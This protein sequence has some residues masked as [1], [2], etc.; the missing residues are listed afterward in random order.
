MHGV[1]GRYRRIWSVTSSIGTHRLAV[2]PSKTLRPPLVVHC[3]TARS[4]ASKAASGQRLSTV[5]LSIAGTCILLAAPAAMTMIW[6]SAPPLL[7]SDAEASTRPH[8]EN[9]YQQTTVE[10]VV[11]DKSTCCDI[12]WVKESRGTRADCSVHETTGGDEHLPS[13][14]N[15]KKEKPA[16]AFNPSR[17]KYFEIK[18]ESLTPATATKTR[19]YTKDDNK[20]NN[21]LHN[22]IV[23]LPDLFSP[24]ECEMIVGDAERI[25][26]ENKAKNV[27]G[28]KT[29]S[30]TLYSRFGPESQGVMDRVLGEHVLSFLELRMPNLAK[31]L[32]QDNKRIPKHG[33]SNAKKTMG[34]YWDD[35][36]VIKYDVSNQ[37][38]PHE[39]MRDLTIVIPLNP[40]DQYPLTGGGTRF[41]LEGTTPDNADCGGG[42]SIKPAPG[43]G[44]LFN[45]E[46]THSGNT[47]ETGTRFVL[48]TSVNLD[49]DGI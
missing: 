8:H 6:M 16:A 10:S 11:V 9:H 42:V 5:P 33:Y 36:V 22:T 47:F 21:L 45:G 26:N 49:E 1:L 3:L 37:L 35:P 43:S 34:T 14:K 27:Q 31:K 29:E 24:K 4:F 12:S 46:I 13:T 40:L 44:I 23:V 48:M 30:W 18:L 38:A 25:L 41:W 15:N 20:T 32:F 39:D 17:S 7:V 2:V 19:E 28:C